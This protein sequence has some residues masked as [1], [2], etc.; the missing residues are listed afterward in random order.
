MKQIHFLQLLSTICVITVKPYAG[1]E[2]SSYLICFYRSKF[3]CVKIS[4]QKTDK[5]HISL[6]LMVLKGNSF[7]L[8]ISRIIE[9]KVKVSHKHEKGSK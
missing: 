9:Y 5:N 7:V 6:Y 8:F 1:D 2:N 3:V 4:F